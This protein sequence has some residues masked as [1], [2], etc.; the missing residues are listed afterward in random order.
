[1]LYSPNF[2]EH[3]I[4][5]TDGSGGCA[6][7]GT[8]ILVAYISQKLFPREVWY[9]TVEKEE[10]VIKW[11]LSSFRYHLLGREFTLEMDHEALQSMERMTDTN[12]NCSAS[13]FSTSQARPTPQLTTSLTVP[14]RVLK[15]RS[16]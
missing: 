8:A 7:P 12:G 1:M 4:L 14:A 13:A 10:L 6:S 16:A 2:D 5:Q 11:A 9:S 3:F 15:G